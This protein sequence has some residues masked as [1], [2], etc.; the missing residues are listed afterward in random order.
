MQLQDFSV[1]DLMMRA[2]VILGILIM[3]L[4]NFGTIRKNRIENEKMVL[5]KYYNNFFIQN[6]PLYSAYVASILLGISLFRVGSLLHVE[7][8]STPYIKFLNFI[9]VGSEETIRLK[10]LIFT[11]SFTGALLFVASCILYNL[12]QVQLG[13]N[14]SL[15]ID[16]KEHYTLKTDRLFKIVRHPMYLFEILFYI[17]ASIALLSWALLLWTVC[18]HI[19]LIIIKS[20]SEDRL[21]EHYYGTKYLKYKKEVSA[22][23]PGIRW[24]K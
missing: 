21:L 16:I 23:M 4:S 2:I 12:S 19:P 11:V 15:F 24:H 8:S 14:F 22:F 3:T 6:I 10:S 20:K 5:V 1:L 17:T 7:M 18:I 9:L 13:T